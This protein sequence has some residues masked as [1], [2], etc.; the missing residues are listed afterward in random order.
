MEN[1][2]TLL[3]LMKQSHC[4]VE[5]VAK[6][7]AQK[8]KINTFRTQ[9]KVKRIHI[10]E[11]CW[12]HLTCWKLQGVGGVRGGSFFTKTMKKNGQMCYNPQYTKEVWFFFLL[13]FNGTPLKNTCISILK[14]FKFFTNGCAKYYNG[15]IQGIS[16]LELKKSDSFPNSLPQ[17]A[18]TQLKMLTSTLLRRSDLM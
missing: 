10:S 16:Q 18:S 6:Q 2:I 7:L 5:L 4:A 1:F 11:I 9:E 17:I 15:Q 13:F 12:M 3:C 14:G 8:C